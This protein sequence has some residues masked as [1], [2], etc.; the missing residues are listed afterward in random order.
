MA[1][2]YEELMAEGRAAL[3]NMEY[4]SAGTAFRDALSIQP[5][6]HEAALNLGIALSRSDRTDEAESILK[7]ALLLNPEDPLTNLETGMLYKNKGVHAEAVDFFENVIDLAPRS[8]YAEK[9]RELLGIEKKKMKGKRWNAAVSAG[10][11]IDSNVALSPEDAALPQGVSDKKDSR[12]IIFLAGNYRLVNSNDFTSTA[13]YSYYASFHNDLSRY[14]IG[15]HHLSLNGNFRLGESSSIKAVCS[16]D[17]TALDGDAFSAALNLSPS[18]TLSTE[19]GFETV[20][21]YTFTDTDYKNSGNYPT[22]S[23]RTGN[24]HTYGISMLV[25]MEFMNTEFGYSLK[26]ASAKI[27]YQ[28][29]TSPKAFLAFRIGLPLEI[30]ADIKAEYSKRNYGGQNPQTNTSR[31]DKVKSYSGALNKTIYK[32]YMIG[33][34]YL[35]MENESSITAYNYKRSITGLIITVRF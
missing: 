33:L 1:A 14:N 6:S 11:Q 27:D 2:D 7:K 20:F 25:P 10:Y 32:R 22:N 17:T 23:D 21:K 28:E 35:T 5:E 4:E 13:G 9:A 30:T 18:L 12:T 3:E 19:S 34:S 24:S 26:D 31:D 8:E 15:A 16:Y 29:Y